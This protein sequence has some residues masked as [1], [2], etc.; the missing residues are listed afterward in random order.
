[1]SRSSTSLRAVGISAVAVLA[2]FV[3]FGVASQAQQ[4]STPLGEDKSAKTRL[5]D[6]GAKLLQ[7]NSPLGPTVKARI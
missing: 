5:L 6:V 2:L 7:R 1:M 3:G 4:D